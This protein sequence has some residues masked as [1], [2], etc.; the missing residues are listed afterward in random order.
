MLQGSGKVEQSRSAE[1]LKNMSHF[2]SATNFP[3]AGKV[4]ILAQKRLTDQIFIAKI[5]FFV[6]ELLR[7]FLSIGG[8]ENIQT[9]HFLRLPPRACSRF[10]RQSL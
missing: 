9:A 2:A 6:A 1:G 3:K 4:R 7:I 5:R 10:V 8:A